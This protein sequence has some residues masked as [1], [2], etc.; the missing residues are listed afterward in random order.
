MDPW[1]QNPAGLLRSLPGPGQTGN[2]ENND[3]Y[4]VEEI[5]SLLMT[6]MGHMCTHI[7]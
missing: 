7:W 3:E 6:R 2:G 5:T 4:T 1:T